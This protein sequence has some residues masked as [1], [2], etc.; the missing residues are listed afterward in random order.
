[1]NL[2][3]TFLVGN[4]S[5]KDF[6]EGEDGALIGSIFSIFNSVKY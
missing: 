2:N 1:M 5:D 4:F 3:Q 6:S